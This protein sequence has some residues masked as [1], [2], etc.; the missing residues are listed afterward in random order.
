ME[1]E[2][3]IKDWE[4]FGTTLRMPDSALFKEMLEGLDEYLVVVDKDNHLPTERLLMAL[5]LKQQKMINS[6]LEEYKKNHQKIS[7]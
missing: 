1:F 4:I 3:E 7:L 2:D 6:L 5:F